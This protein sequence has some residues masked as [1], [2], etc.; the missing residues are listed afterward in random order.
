MGVKKEGT[1]FATAIKKE[2]GQKSYDNVR[3]RLYR[4]NY[5]VQNFNSNAPTLGLEL[6]RPNPSWHNQLTHPLRMQ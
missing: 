2:Q 1:S 4:E 3:N 6:H 5:L